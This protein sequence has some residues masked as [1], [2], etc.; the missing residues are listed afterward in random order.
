MSMCLF[1]QR[2]LS[3]AGADPHIY[4]AGTK[5]VLTAR[6]WGLSATGTMEVLGNTKFRGGDVILVRAQ[7]TE[8]GGFLGFIVIV[9]P[10]RLWFGRPADDPSGLI[11]SSF[12]GL[13][14]AI[15]SGFED[16]NE[17]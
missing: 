14:F 7:V 10:L 11:I 8:L 6:W 15:A 9:V 17:K 12:V 13:L 5:F 3:S 16:L 2:S 4:K 1:S